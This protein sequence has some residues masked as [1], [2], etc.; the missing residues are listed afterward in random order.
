MPRNPGHQSIND[1]LRR[2]GGR[3]RAAGGE[4]ASSA[5]PA[6]KPRSTADAGEGRRPESW[7]VVKPRVDMNKALRQATGRDQ[8][9]A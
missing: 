8:Y 2:A 9:L 6:P 3:G 7:P 1:A 4:S 5:E